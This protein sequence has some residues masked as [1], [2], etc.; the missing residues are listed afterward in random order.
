MIKGRVD[1]KASTATGYAWFV[2]IKGVSQVGTQLV[3]IPPCRRSLEKV[4]DYN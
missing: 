2:W 4:E 3:W 1:P